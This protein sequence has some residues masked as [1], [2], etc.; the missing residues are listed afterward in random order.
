MTALKHEPL[1]TVEP[2]EHRQQRA[3]AER[4][5]CEHCGKTFA[6][7]AVVNGPVVRCPITLAYSRSRKLYCDHCDLIQHWHQACDRDGAFL[8]TVVMKP[9]FYRNA[10]RINRFLRAHPEAAGV[11]QSS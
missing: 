5:E 1:S 6:G 4:I 2:T 7:G 3:S 8:P 10:T 11:A 9:A